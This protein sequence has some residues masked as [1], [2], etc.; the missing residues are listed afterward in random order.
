MLFFFCFVF[1]SLIG[2][3]RDQCSGGGSA[4]KQLPSLHPH[5][6]PF[7]TPLT[8]HMPRPPTPHPSTWPC[9]TQTAPWRWAW[10]PPRP[11]YP[12]GWLLRVPSSS[13]LGLQRSSSTW[14][15]LIPTWGRTY[16]A[17]RHW[18]CARLSLLPP[19]CWLSW[20][21]QILWRYI[22]IAKCHYK[23]YSTCKGINFTGQIRNFVSKL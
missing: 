12:R 10:P 21:L 20:L 3:C 18:T 7:P 2:Y 13:R 1:L 6:Q 23:L 5:R 17:L 16:F 19:A 11:S 22:M 4:S 8:S 15:H 14:T 9:T